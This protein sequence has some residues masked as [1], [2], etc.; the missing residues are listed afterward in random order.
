[1]KITLKP[2]VTE[3][4]RK[5]LSEDALTEKFALELAHTPENQLFN[6]ETQ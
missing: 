6:V 4:L 2:K 5:K 1:M 3:E